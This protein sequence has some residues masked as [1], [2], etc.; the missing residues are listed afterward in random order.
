MNLDLCYYKRPSLKRLEKGTNPE[1]TKKN[2]IIEKRTKKNPVLFIF[3]Y[4]T[5][6][7]IRTKCLE[8]NGSIPLDLIQPSLK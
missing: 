3:L 8:V 2:E 7:N 5:R 6:L 1:L 4:L